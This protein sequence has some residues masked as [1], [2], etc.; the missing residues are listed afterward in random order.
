MNWTMHSKPTISFF[1]PAYNDEENLPVLIPKTVSLLRKICSA[2]EV[3][4]IDD[5]SP[6]NTGKVADKLAKKYH[7]YVKVIHHAKNKGYGGALLSGFKH[8]NKYP[9]V[10]YTDGDNQYDVSVLTDMLPHIKTYHAVIG[11]RIM[12]EVSLQRKLQS[13]GY[14]GLIRFLFQLQQHDVNCAIR[15]YRRTAL[16][17]IHLT[18][19]SAFLPAE[20]IIKLNQKGY[21]IKEV[22]VQHYPRTHGEASGGKLSVIVPTFIEMLKYFLHKK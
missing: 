12:R 16:K 8:A 18:S 11:R 7:P 14:N 22:P 6:D 5:A 13:I 1:C 17:N 9:L 2:F 15:L 10:F 4:I 19:T 21:K 3:V 20:S